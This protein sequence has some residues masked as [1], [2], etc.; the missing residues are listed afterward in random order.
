MDSPD[1]LGGYT[2]STFQNKTSAL[3]ASPVPAHRPVLGPG[4]THAGAEPA[5]W[6][7]PGPRAPSLEAVEIPLL[8]LPRPPYNPASHPAL[9][10]ASV[11]C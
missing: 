10:H 3:F 8:H 7:S 9:T 1:H 4:S 11:Y 5:T 2:F 6:A